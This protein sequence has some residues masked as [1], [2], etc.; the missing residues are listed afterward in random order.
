M[1]KVFSY[2]KRAAKWYLT[3]LGTTCAMCP[4]CMV[5]PIGMVCIN[6]MREQTVSNKHSKAA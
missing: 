1:K 5:P 3:A 2:F 4:S 6:Q